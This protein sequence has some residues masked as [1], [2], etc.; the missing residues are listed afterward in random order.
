MCS[1]IWF[2]V[3][4]LSFPNLPQYLSTCETGIIQPTEDLD[5]SIRSHLMWNK[6][7]KTLD[8]FLCDSVH[9]LGDLGPVHPNCP[10]K[11]KL[12]NQ[13]G[14]F[15]C[16]VFFWNFIFCRC[17]FK[18]WFQ[19]FPEAAS[20][21]VLW[22]KG[23]SKFCKFHRKTPLLEF[24]FKKSEALNLNKKRL[25]QV[26]S[27]EICKI[28]KS[29]YFEEKKWIIRLKFLEFFKQREILQK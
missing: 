13:S 4:G 15:T 10:G 25:W 18:N 24:L 19:S 5:T 9:D 14:G 7:M 11:I 23:F 26:F 27:W 2:G 22:N 17:W 1:C 28:S 12:H 8:Y 20:R 6:E 29:T 21:G 16:R 3:F